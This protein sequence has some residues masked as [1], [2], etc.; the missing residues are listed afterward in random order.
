MSHRVGGRSRGVAVGVVVATLLGGGQLLRASAAGSTPASSF[1]PITPCRLFDTRAGVDNIGPRAAPL[2]PQ[3]TL[4]ARVWGTNGNCTIPDGA[5]GVSLGVVIVNP[6][7]GSF[8][9]VFPGDAVRPLSSNVN[10]QSGQA[11]TPNAVTG[12]LSADGRLGFYNLA[13]TVD[14]L[15]DIVGYYEVSTP[16]GSQGSPGPKGDTGAQ[17]SPGPRGTTGSP[18]LAG[19]PGVPGPPGVRGDPGAPGSQGPPGLKGD[20]GAPGAPALTDTVVVS[21]NFTVLSGQITSGVAVCPLSHPNVTG[22]GHSI[23]DSVGNLADVLSSWPWI[24]NNNGWNVRVRSGALNPFNVAVYAVC[25][26]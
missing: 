16:G 1:V 3:E 18:G 10:W 5:T 26:T 9:T 25:A 12:A 19:L 17:G 13:G 6:T 15:V 23:A 4:L 21:S 7:A 8:L 11:P 20:T 2:G 22:G 24:P 14:L